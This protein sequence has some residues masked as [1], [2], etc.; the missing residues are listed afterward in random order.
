MGTTVIFKPTAVQKKALIL[1]KSGAKHILLFGG[2]RSGKTTVLVMA[3]IYRAL[4]FA[5]S[6]FAPLK[7]Q[8]LAAWKGGIRNYAV[9][10]NSAEIGDI[11]R[12]FFFGL[13]KAAIFEAGTEGQAGQN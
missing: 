7:Q 8:E 4:C 12:R 5:G 9:F 13:E 1:L 10:V 2:S 3:I 11:L 6:R